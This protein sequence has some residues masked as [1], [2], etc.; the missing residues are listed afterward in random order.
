MNFFKDMKNTLEE[1]VKLPSSSS[2]SSSPTSDVSIPTKSKDAQNV[3]KSPLPKYP[4]G[5][6]L[7]E[8]HNCSS[9]PGANEYNIR[10]DNYLND[11]KKIKSG[12]F[13]LPLRGIDLFLTKDTPGNVGRFVI[14]ICCVALRV[15][16]SA[17]LFTFPPCKC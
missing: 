4:E 17:F 9:E 10:G 13:L 6:E 12:P 5:A 1:A 14:V 15:R 3:L 11:K 16:L 7:G 2:S 8:H